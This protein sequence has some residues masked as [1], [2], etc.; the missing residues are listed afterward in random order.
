[1][2]VDLKIDKD[3]DEPGTFTVSPSGYDQ[4]IFRSREAD[5]DGKDNVFSGGELLMSGVTLFAEGAKASANLD[6]VSYSR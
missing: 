3:F 1:M 6:D 5:C 2:D 4:L